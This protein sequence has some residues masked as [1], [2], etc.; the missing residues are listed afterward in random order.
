MRANSVILKFPGEPELTEAAESA[1]FVGGAS[2]G[3]D[4]PSP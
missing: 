2:E 4:G 3:E 1:R